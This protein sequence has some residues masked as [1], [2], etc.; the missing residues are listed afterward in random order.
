MC[1]KIIE[2]LNALLKEEIPDKLKDKCDLSLR[3]Y[4]KLEE[5]LQCNKKKIDEQFNKEQIKYNTELKIPIDKVL[6]DIIM[7]SFTRLQEIY[8]DYNV[9]R[10]KLEDSEK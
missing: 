8:H 9:D 1:K 6:Y 2:D 3:I 7:K 4:Q 5:A 10:I